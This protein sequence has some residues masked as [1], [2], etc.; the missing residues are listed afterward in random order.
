MALLSSKDGGSNAEMGPFNAGKPLSLGAVGT[1]SAT[2]EEVSDSLGSTN[3]DMG[4]SSWSEQYSPVADEASVSPGNIELTTPF[5]NPAQGLREITFGRK[6]GV[7]RRRAEEE[8]L[9]LLIGT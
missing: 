9:M 6:R 5:F 1:T 8:E 4:D 3:L 2:A 7:K